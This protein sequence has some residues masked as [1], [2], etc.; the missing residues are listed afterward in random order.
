MAIYLVSPDPM[1][2]IDE[3]LNYYQYTML[4]DVK[5]CRRKPTWQNELP[6]LPQRA[7]RYQTQY[8]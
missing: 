2:V 1:P 5:P 3:V 4:P 7:R 6:D 8:L